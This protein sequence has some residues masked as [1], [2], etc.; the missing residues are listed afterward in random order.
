MHRN[1][2]RSS[3]IGYLYDC[4]PSKAKLHLASDE[5][6]DFLPQYPGQVNQIEAVQAVW[7]MPVE[8]Q[9]HIL[10]ELEEIGALQIR[11]E[12]VKSMICTSDQK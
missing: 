6:R 10:D 8:C 12:R 3:S 9:A 11:Q 7:I 4:L 1:R 5:V 2:L